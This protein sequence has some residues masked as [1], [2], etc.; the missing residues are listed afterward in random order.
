[1]ELA[2]ASSGIGDPNTGY[3]T[4]LDR[5]ASPSPDRRFTV[6]KS[7]GALLQ[8][9]VDAL[10]PENCGSA[11]ANR[12]ARSGHVCYDSLLMMGEVNHG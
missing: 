7:G 6:S 1:M 8:A 2:R 3:V 11:I 5:G 12:L 10:L 9:D 4:R